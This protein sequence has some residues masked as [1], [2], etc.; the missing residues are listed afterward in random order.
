MNFARGS[1]VKKKI[2]GEVRQALLALFK[3]LGVGFGEGL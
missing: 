3:E 1:N 2:K